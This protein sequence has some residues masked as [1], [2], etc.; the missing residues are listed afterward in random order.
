MTQNHSTPFASV[1]TTLRE[2][3]EAW[4]EYERAREERAFWNHDEVGETDE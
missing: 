2:F 3:R 1:A 4:A